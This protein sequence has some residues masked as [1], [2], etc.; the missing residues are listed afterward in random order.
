MAWAQ[1]ATVIAATGGFLGLQ[2]FW[3]APALD[4]LGQRL[5]RLE[6]RLDRLEGREPL[7]RRR[8]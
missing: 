4:A 1:A 7:G 2:S 6:A 8:V 3:I 5:D